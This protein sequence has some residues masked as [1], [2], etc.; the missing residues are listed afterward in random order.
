L[1]WSKEAKM[2]SD[3]ERERKPKKTKKV[4]AEG[5]SGDE[6]EPKKKRRGKLKKSGEPGAAEDDALF[7]DE[8]DGDN[9]PAK[10]VCFA[11]RCFVVVAYDLSSSPERS[12]K[13]GSQR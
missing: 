11:H 1:E 4:K 2:E 9:K 10:K 5:G 6:A 7:S 13:E 8:E 12:Q 3:E